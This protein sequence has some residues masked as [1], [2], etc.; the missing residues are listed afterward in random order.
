MEEGFTSISK[1]EF[2]DPAGFANA[3]DQVFD[4]GEIKDISDVAA[5]KTH[6]DQT[7]Y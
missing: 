7:T 5:A 4:V 2:R 1:A 6:P 3:L